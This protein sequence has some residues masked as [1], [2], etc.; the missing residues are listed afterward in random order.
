MAIISKIQAEGLHLIASSFLALT[1][2]TIGANDSVNNIRRQIQSFVDKLQKD[3]QVHFG[4][5][6]GYSG[7]RE[8][9][10]KYYKL[11]KRLES[12]ATIEELV[13]L[14]NYKSPVIVVYAFEILKSR[15]YQG[16]KNI[17][18]SHPNDTAWYWTAGGCTGVLN[19]VNW[20]MLRRLRP[21]ADQK[22]SL[23]NA[24]YDLFCGRFKKEDELFSCN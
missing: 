21:I 2:L 24:E 14:T 9:K 3:N 12:K 20:F 13:E 15:N 7:K 17:F 4:Y 5:P 22:N 23:T 19:R 16:L 18:L 1:S 8:T 11:F 10:N 6:V